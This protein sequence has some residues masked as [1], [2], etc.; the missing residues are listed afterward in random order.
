MSRSLKVRAECLENVRLALKRNAYPSQKS[1]SQELGL[2][3]GTISKFLNGKP[4]DYSYFRE[5]CD[6]LGLDWQAIAN[7]DNLND[8]P[9]PVPVPVKSEVKS[10][11]KR[12]DWGEAI[13]VSVFHGRQSE[14]K[15]LSQWLVEDRCRLVALLGMG[16]IG[17]SALS[18]KL[19]QLLES[20]FH[21][22]I[23]RSLRNAPP[24]ATL[25]ID[26]VT[27]VSHQQEIKADIR[28]LIHYLRNAR[29]LV[30]LDNMETILDA[31]QAGQYRSGYEDYGGLLRTVA[32]VQHQ[33]CVILTSREKPAEIATFE[34]VE[35][36]V[37]AMRL[38]GSP[39]AAYALLQAK[40]VT[41]SVDDKQLLCDRYSNSPL[42]LK[43][44]AT[45]IQNLFS[46]ELSEFLKQDTII[47][48]GIRRLLAQQFERLS[49]LEQTIMYCLAINREWVNIAE[50]EQDIVPTVSRGR[51]LEALEYLNGRSLIESKSSN[52]TQQPVVME[53]VIDRL[54]E[55]VTNE[56]TTVELSLFNSHALIKTTVKDYVRESQER[57]ILQPIAEQFCK[58]FSSPKALEQQIA[59]VLLQ[60][61]SPK[62]KLSHYGA[63]N[64][65]NLCCHLQFNLTGYNFSDLTIRQA[66]L[67]N[68]NLPHVN[69][70]NSNFLQS[71]FTQTFGCILTL[72]FS[73]KN[74]L[75]ATGDSNNDVR[76]WR[77]VDSQLLFVCEGHTD[78]VRTLVFSADGNTVISAG[79]DQTIRLWD[80]NTGQCLKTLTGNASRIGSLALSPDGRTLIT[81]S[82]DRTVRVWDIF[83]EE[84]IKNLQ[85]HNKQVWAVAISPDGRTI[86]SGSEDQT[87]RLW[88]IN[89]GQCLKLLAEHTNWV[90]TVAFSPDSKI[91]ASGSHDNTIKLWDLNTGQCLKTLVGH[92]KWV[93]SVAFSPDGQTLA[94]GSEDQTVRLWNINTG[95]CF[96]TLQGHTN[97]IWSVA[98]SPD[99]QTLASGSDDQTIKLW[100]TDI[101]KCIKT[102]QGCTRKIWS[103]ACSLNGET[104]A[105]SGDEKIVRLWN[106]NSGECYQ[107]LAGHSSRI[108]SVAFSPD[109]YTLV[110]GGEDQTVRLWDINTG[111]CLKILEGHTKQVWSVAFSPNGRTIAS[112]SEDQT[113][114]LW[115]IKT[116]QCLQTLQGHN[117]WVWSVAFSPDGRFL[118]SASYDH[119]IKL[120]DSSTGELLKTL[121]GHTNYALAVAFSADSRLLATGSY[122]QTIKIWNVNTGKCLETLHEHTDPVGSVC[123]SPKEPLLASASMDRTFK[124][125]DIS[126]IY[127]QIEGLEANKST[128]NQSSKSTLGKCLKTFTGH[129]DVVWTLRFSCDGTMVVTGNWD[130]TIKI[131]DV[132]TRECLKTLRAE[133]P[134]E[135]MNITNVTGITAAQKASLKA[136]GAV[137]KDVISARDKN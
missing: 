125:W 73:P 87:V 30:I 64:L 20:E 4:I 53:Y 92:N 79:D 44:V 37:R 93:W 109:G 16:G 108:E 2:A 45:S 59:I 36:A 48:N 55:R 136:L 127:S 97:R 23:W 133:R 77:L 99:S 34:G 24:L 21:F 69:F 80:V 7:I 104:I 40:G 72:A 76:I 62:V 71:V 63:G 25:L 121:E 137:E 134:Y 68:R 8:T 103:V 78:W 110:S 75:L 10:V 118:A 33:S 28:Q 132:N 130:E 67:Q 119:T 41:G 100:N 58:T 85:G 89:T 35:M 101:G 5:I 111:Q 47:F 17:K 39:E 84:C 13:D 117:N 51:I 95:Q 122:D 18:V 22:I 88:D 26:L 70:T 15:I 131:W 129:S 98:F 106:V 128:K 120:W 91:L 57:L 114:R 3:L 113:V 124:F 56:L 9:L 14:L 43:I 60:L 115:D 81:S 1:L 61:Q 65:I 12:V 126:E 123:F 74:K 82:E 46:G 116:G 135:G 6:K 112:G 96:T 50:L 27:F 83:T 29:C 90:W 102:M 52:Y 11:D 66:Y 38:Q 31:E 49:S 94:S 105:S 54:I 19:A 86:A 32:E 107:T 42:A